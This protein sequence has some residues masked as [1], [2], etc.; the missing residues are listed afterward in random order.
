MRIES[1]N[2]KI[3]VDKLIA[4][5]NLLFPKFAPNPIQTEVKIYSQASMQTGGFETTLNVK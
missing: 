3:Y 2:H 5:V 4:Q 1:Q